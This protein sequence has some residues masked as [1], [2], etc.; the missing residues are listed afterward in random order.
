M[1][2]NARK[3]QS[4]NSA[5]KN[6]SIQ[7]FTFPRLDLIAVIIYGEENKL[8]DSHY[9]VLYPLV[10]LPLPYATA[11]C[12]KSYSHIESKHIHIRAVSSYIT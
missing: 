10:L 9:V 7:N 11:F 8:C 1:I 3:C 2:N 4:H 6:V 5:H 12:I